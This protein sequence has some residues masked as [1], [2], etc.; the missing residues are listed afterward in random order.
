MTEAFYLTG[1]IEKYGTGFKRIKAWLNE[2]PGISLNIEELSGFIRVTIGLLLN[3]GLNEGLKSLFDII[4]VNPGVQ[5]KDIP[6]L[7]EGRPLK[8][9]ERQISELIKLRKIERRGSKKTG[10][11][12]HFCLFTCF[13]CLYF[14]YLN[15]CPTPS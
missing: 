12:L 10:G 7:L 13:F 14:F 5:A 6:Q 3:E 11:S 8:T 15:L 1:D 9:I 2:Y 4:K